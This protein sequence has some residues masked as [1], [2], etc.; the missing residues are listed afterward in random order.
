MVFTEN[1][2]KWFRGIFAVLFPRLEGSYES[3]TGTHVLEQ[4]VQGARHRRCI[5][6]RSTPQ[7]REKGKKMAEP[8]ETRQEQ[9]TRWATSSRRLTLSDHRAGS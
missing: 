1:C 3:C 2:S 8:E 5:V 6:L 4:A 7:H 9:E